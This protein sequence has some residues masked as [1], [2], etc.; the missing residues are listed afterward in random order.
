MSSPILSYQKRNSLIHRT[1]A[2]MKLLALL[3]IAVALYLTGLEI[4][5]ILFADTEGFASLLS[6]FLSR[7]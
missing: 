2:L 1:P 6:F 3:G 5:G 7:S 4:H